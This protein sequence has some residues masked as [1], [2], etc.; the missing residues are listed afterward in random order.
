MPVTVVRATAFAG[1]FK[2]QNMLKNSMS[3]PCQKPERGSL[4]QKENQ[5]GSTMVSP[6][7]KQGQS[8]PVICQTHRAELPVTQSGILGEGMN[9]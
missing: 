1:C 2:T 9:L 3:P 5:M 7:L 8:L 6:L 4:L